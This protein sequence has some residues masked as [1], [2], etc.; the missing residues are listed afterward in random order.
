MKYGDTCGVLLNETNRWVKAET[1]IS[2]RIIIESVKEKKECKGLAV[3]TE[4]LK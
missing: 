2:A 4:A 1:I 3:M